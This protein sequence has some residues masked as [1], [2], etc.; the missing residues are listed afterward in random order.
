MNMELFWAVELHGSLL[1]AE[2]LVMGAL[3]RE[4][5]RGSHYREDFTERDDEK[6]LRHSIVHYNDG[7][8]SLSYKEVDVSLFEP[9]ERSY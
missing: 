4:E 1:V 3:A 2:A 6:W 5:S 8:P 9:K 7:D